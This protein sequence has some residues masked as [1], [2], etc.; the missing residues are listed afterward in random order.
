[1]AF[2]NTLL[3]LMLV[4]G[5]CLVAAC[6][7]E[8]NGDQPDGGSGDPIDSGTG[9]IDSS[10]LTSDADN[11]TQYIVYVHSRD[12]LFRMDP[13]TFE[14]TTIGAFGTGMDFI[15]DLA[16]T[17]DGTI[18]VISKTKLYTADPDTGVATYVADVPGVDN[19]ALTFL[20]DGTLLASDDT[21]G[22]RRV[23]PATGQVTEVGALGNMFAT[24]GDLVAV[25]DGTMYCLADKGPDG[26]AYDDNWLITVNPGTGAGT[27][28]KHIGFGQVFGAAFINGKL[29]AFTANGQII[30][31]DPSTPG[32]GVVVATDAALE[33]WG[34]GVT[35][36][37]PGVE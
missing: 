24:A 26:D 17:P 19:V 16:V 2:R 10:P 32:P 9:F 25:E 37:V 4:L 22:V 21:G 33:Y 27:A 34:A 23:D 6:N 35:P 3:N 1:M 14:L 29:L 20:P 31:V 7:P 30:E 18:Y 8:P 36:L 12:T 11:T 28:V 15:N 5:S 13:T